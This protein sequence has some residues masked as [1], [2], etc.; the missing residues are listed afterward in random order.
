MNFNLLAEGLDG[1]LAEIVAKLQSLIDSF[2]IYIVIA[3]DLYR[4]RSRGGCRHLGRVH[5]H[6]DRHCTPQRREDQRPRHDQ[7]SRHRHRHYLRRGNGRAASHQRLVRL[8]RRVN[9][10][11]FGLILCR[12]CGTARLHTSLY[13]PSRFPRPPRLSS[14]SYPIFH[15]RKMRAARCSPPFIFR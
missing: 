8:G 10:I 5:R 6:Q 14:K 11:S 12:A 3:L 2:W 15:E 7:K 1:S 4:H 9:R 13:A